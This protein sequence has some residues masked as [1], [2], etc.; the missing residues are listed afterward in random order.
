MKKINEILALTLLILYSTLFLSIT[1]FFVRL[2]VAAYFNVTRGKFY[3][4]ISDIF[5]SAKAGAAAGVTLG[6]GLW[7]LEKINKY[8]SNNKN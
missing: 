7:V 3:F 1:G 2:A 6:V 4:D 5:I 8:K